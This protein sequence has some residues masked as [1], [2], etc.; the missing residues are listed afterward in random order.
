MAIG[1]QVFRL[2]QCAGVAGCIHHL[3]VRA[4][5]PSYP[6]HDAG[7]EDA[8]Q[9][10]ASS[11]LDH[12]TEWWVRWRLP[13]DCRSDHSHRIIG[14]TS[15]LVFDEGLADDP[16]LWAGLGLRMVDVWTVTGAR[17]GWMV[18]GA[19]RNE[20][21]FWAGVAE[22]D[23]LDRVRLDTPARLVSAYFITELDGAGDLRDS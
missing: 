7:A 6:N 5:Q 3:L 22:A 16:D 17:A 13:V 10:F 23:H 8:A 2:V 12:L 9:A 21:A 11:A 19:A 4:A 14:E 20:A 1:T 15:D 18:L